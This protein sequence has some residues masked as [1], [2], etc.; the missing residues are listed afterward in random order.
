MLLNYKKGL[1]ERS[2]TIPTWSLVY[3]AIPVGMCTALGFNITFTLVSNPEQTSCY[4]PVPDTEPINSLVISL[5]QTVLYFVLY[6]FLGWLTD[7][8]INRQ[9]AMKISIVLCWFGSLLQLV[10]YCVQYG[11]CGHPTSFAKYGI[12]LVALI[13]LVIGTACYQVN[14]LA[15]GLDQLFEKANSHIRSFIHWII[16][17]QYI[18]FLIS[19]IAFVNGTVY[20]GELLLITGLIVFLAC[21]VSLLC[22]QVIAHK[23]HPTP[24]LLQRNN[25]YHLVFQVLLY[26][27]R[28]KSPQKRSALTYWE[29]SIPNRISL[30]K[31]KYGGPFTTDEIE[32]VKTFF[33]IIAVL[34]S[35]FGFFIPNYLLV[36]GVLPFV[37]VFNGATTDVD[38]FGSFVLWNCFNK[39][40]IVAVPILELIILP[41]LPKLEYFVLNPHKWFG[42]ACTFMLLTLLSMIVIDTVG[43]YV[44]SIEPFC[45]LTTFG[46]TLN[47]SYFYYSI[48]LLFGSLANIIGTISILEFICSQAP[49]NMSG[50]LTGTFYL[51]RGVFV[52]IG[53]YL[54]L[55]FSYVGSTEVGKITCS[56]WIILINIVISVVGFIVYMMIYRWYTS[57][58]RGEEYNA[59]VIVEEVYDNY[60]NVSYANFSSSEIFQAVSLNDVVDA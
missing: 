41:L 30:G 26:A 38:G 17:A 11:T 9:R 37:N 44:T 53:P 28:H 49:I 57:R 4:A 59:N 23:F 27:K 45:F 13:C 47:V 20:Q 50:M 6:P 33:R 32:N 29:N 54:Q 19:Y 24:K 31:S 7:T 22:N 58:K 15:Y 10:S 25:P 14:I 3:N 48:P 35:T 16:W 40:I 34:V 21:S 46:I 36:N 12:S 1:K 8:Y 2:L 18:G 51:I 52:A 43:Y 60:L 42:I 39:I 5:I 56:F 55:P